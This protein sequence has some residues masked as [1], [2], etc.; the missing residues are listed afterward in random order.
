MEAAANI[1]IGDDTALRISGDG[2]GHD[3][4]LDDGESD[5]KTRAGRIQLLHKFSSDLTVRLGADYENLTGTG[6]GSTYEGVYRYNPATRQYGFVGSG[7]PRSD[8]EYDAASQAYRSTVRALPTGRNFAPLA[9]YPYS[10][11]VF[12][13]VNAEI[14]YETPYGKLV[15]EPS[16]RHGGGANRTAVPGYTVDPNEDDEQYEVETR[17]LGKRIGMFDYTVGGL[18]YDETNDGH[19]SINQQA[20]VVY[21]DFHQSTESYAVFGRATAHLTDT[22]RLVGGIRYTNDDKDFNGTSQRL[23]IACTLMTPTGP[24]CPTAPLFSLV[25]TL[26]QQTIPHPAVSGGAT[27]LIVN[28]RFSGA[29]DTRGDVNVDAELPTDKVT[30]RAAVEYDLTPRSLLYFSYETG[31]RTGGFSL[32]TG[33]E[34]YQPEKITAYTF[35]AKNRFFDNRLQLNLEAYRWL[36]S[37]QQVNHV[38]IDLAG[39]TGSFTQNIGRSTNQGI[40]AEARYLLT[41]TTV[42]STDIQYL[43]ATYDSFVYQAPIG[44]APVVTGCRQS[45]TS[46][47]L[48]TVDCSGR[49]TFNSPKWTANFGIEQ[50]LRLPGYK[51]VASADTQYRSSRY[52]GFDYTVQEHQTATF[53]TNAEL[54]LTPDVGRWSLQ[55]YARNLENT[56]YDVDANLFGLG[57]ILTESTNAPRTYGVRV[58]YK[59]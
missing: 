16:Y 10:N 49:P 52:V 35:G 19:Y 7:L 4:Y 25:P 31:Y 56:R 55:A 58:S 45:V 3:G 57:N 53:E 17:F 59:Y 26:A 32:S 38:G 24:N 14:D 18:Y 6:N 50:T 9:D 47:T 21:Q 42:L 39:Q 37:N 44:S 8:G 5:E 34:T 15:V 13:G 29:V 51:L 20:L 40:E 22:L 46:A 12:Y 28:G 41:P 23:L 27:P 2:F 33:Y 30:Y 36:Y 43:D 54:T 1:P 48:R 11:R